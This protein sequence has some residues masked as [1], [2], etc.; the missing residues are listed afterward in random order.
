LPLR[1]NG[2]SGKNKLPLETFV[3]NGGLDLLVSALN[4]LLVME[5]LLGAPVR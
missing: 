3:P 2:F 4:L 5:S 1:E